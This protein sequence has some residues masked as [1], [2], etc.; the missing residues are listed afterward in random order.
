KASGAM[1]AAF[2][3][4]WLGRGYG[5]LSGFV[6]TSDGNAVQ[7]AFIEV[8]EARHPLP[9]ARSASAA[10]RMLEVVSGLS[11]DDLVVALISGGASSLLALP[12]P[13]LTLE[14]KQAV[15]RALLASGA[16]IDEMNCVRKH[17]SAIKGGRL[18]AAAAPARVVSLVLSDIPGDNPAL[19]GSGP[20]IPDA[21]SVDD[22]RRIIARYRLDLPERVLAA[23]SP[24]P[25]PAD[26]AFSNNEIH[27][28]GAA[29]MSLDA[30]A[31]EAAR[32]GLEPHILSDAFAG[33]A[34]D[35]GQVHAALARQILA[36]NQPFTA[37]CLLLSGGETTVTL[38]GKGGKGGRNSEFLLAFARHVAGVAGVVAL[39]AD[40]DGID[41]S[42][43]NAG[44]VADGTS[45]ARM[46][47]AGVDPVACLDGNDSYSAFAAV[48][49][50]LVTGPTGTNVNDFRAILI[51]R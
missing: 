48:G 11:A 39:A 13:G 20:T 10:E 15:N 42:E 1:A 2:E 6:V 47:E 16:P 46:R 3:R 26:S 41:G 17:L 23:L 40:T 38:R 24:A 12:A 22:A 44:A 8:T 29:Q 4:E 19:V 28:V 43:Q 36:R 33:E 35:L 5:A 37:P 25:A 27:L 49:D 31:A 32:R 34:R 18:A 50:L 9:D 30:A 51:D 14:D 45:L 21:T 7:N